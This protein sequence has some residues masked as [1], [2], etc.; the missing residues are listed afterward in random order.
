MCVF[1]NCILKNLDDRD[2]NTYARR[3]S[4]VLLVIMALLFLYISMNILFKDYLRKQPSYQLLGVL[5]LLDGAYCM[6][7]MMQEY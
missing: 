4:E 5:L 1:I 7:F 2:S 3:I 6:D